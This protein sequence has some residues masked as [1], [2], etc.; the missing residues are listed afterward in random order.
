MIDDVL[1]ATEYVKG[2]VHDFRQSNGW[3]IFRWH[4]PDFWATLHALKAV[5]PPEDRQW[6]DETEEWSVRCGPYDDSL[7]AVFRNWA[8]K[9][10]MVKAQL[11]LPMF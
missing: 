6:N 7:G 10:E 8:L 5:V 1:A 11:P 3:W 4:A 9:V 2:W